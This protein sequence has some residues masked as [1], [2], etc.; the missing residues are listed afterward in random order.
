MGITINETYTLPSQIS[1]PSVYARLKGTMEVWKQTGRPSGPIGGYCLE[2][3]FEC[4]VSKETVGD[5]PPIDIRRIHIVQDEPFTGNLYDV[6]YDALKS[7][8]SDYTDDI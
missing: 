1:L 2:A 8:F 4:F 3:N 5:A 6:V 7:E